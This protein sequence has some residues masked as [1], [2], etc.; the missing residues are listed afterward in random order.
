M[1]IL[2]YGYSELQIFRATDILSY[3][4]SELRTVLF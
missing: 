1:D 3:G 2:S 4:H